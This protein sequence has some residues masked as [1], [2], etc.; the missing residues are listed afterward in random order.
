MISVK[1]VSKNTVA[2]VALPV[3]N[4]AARHQSFRRAKRALK[5]EMIQE[6]AS[7]IAQDKIAEA[8]AKEQLKF[9]KFQAEQEALRQ[10]EVNNLDKCNHDCGCQKA[11]ASLE[12]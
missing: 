4:V 10:M 7:L 3:M 2:F 5:E 1:K 8:F 11:S 12:A 6:G 9:E